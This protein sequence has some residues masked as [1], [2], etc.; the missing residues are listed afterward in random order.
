MRLKNDAL[1]I[2]MAFLK[3]LSERS[4][5]LLLYRAPYAQVSIANKE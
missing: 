5:E 3:L 1:D 2:F 4:Y